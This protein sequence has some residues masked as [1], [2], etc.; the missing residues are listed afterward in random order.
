MLKETIFGSLKPLPYDMYK[1]LYQTTGIDIDN[2]RKDM[3]RCL[4]FSDQ[5][6]K[7][8]VGFAKAIPGFKKFDMEDQI[9]L[10][11]CKYY[12]L[13]NPFGGITLEY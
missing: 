10:I 2:R 1:E 9:H 6:I 7:L 11:K 13:Q 12:L 4:S 8:N 5:P 3:I